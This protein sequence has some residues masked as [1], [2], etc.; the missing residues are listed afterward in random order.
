[1]RSLR[2]LLVDDHV[3]FLET[4]ACSLATLP[5]VEVIGRANSGREALVQS[6]RLRPD[7]VFMDLAMPDL[8]GLAATR[9]LKAQADAP[10]VVILTLH[11]S[12][13]Y[14]SAALTAGADRFLRKDDFGAQMVTLLDSF[15]AAVT[16][17]PARAPLP[18]NESERLAALH[19]YNVLDTPP[20]ADF[21]DLTSLAAQVC[22]TPAAFITF[23][24][25]D[26]P[27]CKAKVG[28]MATETPRAIAFCAHAI[29]Q[30][31][32]FVVP[33][34]LEDERFAQHPL[35]TGQP[36]IRFYAGA[37]LLTPDGFA[38]GTL[39]VVA[40]TPHDLSLVQ[41]KA[42]RALSRQVVSQ[43]ERR[44]HAVQ[45]ASV[46]E[47]RART[48]EALRERQHLIDRIA[49]T[50]PD[51][52]YIYDCMTRKIVYA[53]R[54]SASLFGYP[55]ET[56]RQW[57]VDFLK[58]IVHP[59]DWGKFI[60]REERYR[61]A[62]DDEVVELVYRVK[63]SDEKWRW[64][65]SR[66]TVVTRTTEGTPR[67]IIGVAQDVTE[68]RR[69]D[70]ALFEGIQLV[71]LISSLAEKNRL[72][73]E[74]A[75]Q[76]NRLKADFLASVSH[77]LRTPLN[78]ILGYLDL[79]LEDNFGPLSP[80]QRAS[81]VR[82]DK[83]ARQL[84]ALI[85]AVLDV[86]RL[87]MGK[88]KISTAKINVSEFVE[89]LNQET[90]EVLQKKPNLS[91]FCHVQPKGVTLHTDPL[92]MK[93]ILKNLLSNAIKFTEQGNVSLEVAVRDGGLEFAVTDT[94]IGISPEVEPV[95]FEMFRQGESAMTR[96]YEGLGLG[97]Y[98]VRQLIGLLGGTVTVESVVGQ[99]STFRVWTPGLEEGT[100][101][102]QD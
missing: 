100:S 89:A 85:H 19:R 97:L 38:L 13:E 59:K 11:D 71:S 101:R 58:E 26:R 24:D 47:E 4:A 52:L 10:Y 84:C 36:H 98:L 50:V 5:G 18:A 53:N 51:S 3:G 54:Q 14:R 72:L 73:K 99:G 12:S 25:A 66:D 28:L 17:E 92:V 55:P 91:L 96:Q 39:C 90:Q 62:K 77:E 76:A 7:I 86:S 67:L 46:L 45:L 68:R 30:T 102:E 32:V 27:W 23:V 83:S 9:R 20:E 69:G 56:P 41:Q 44:R 82:I 79:L 22:N 40:Q 60:A 64:L 95:I 33:D 70:E 74:E 75:E 31:D 88:L 15:S 6:A 2:V 78:I 1:M 21:D 43:L 65:H 35:V 37:P 42:L 34:T 93:V 29:L 8:D 61:E 49:D 81:V 80:G 63:H 87:E 57:E 94:G 48:L 16:N